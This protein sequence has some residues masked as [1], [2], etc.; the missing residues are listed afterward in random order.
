[1]D[2]LAIQHINLL[3]RKSVLADIPENYTLFAENIPVNSNGTMVNPV[4]IPIEENTD[5]VVWVVGPVVGTSGL[6]IEFKAP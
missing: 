5:Y 1:M 2:V 6:K 4:Q 3:Y